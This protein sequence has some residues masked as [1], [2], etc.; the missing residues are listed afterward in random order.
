MRL[1]RIQPQQKRSWEL[2]KHLSLSTL[3]QYLM[4]FSFAANLSAQSN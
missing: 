3:Q 2:H 4:A 1:S